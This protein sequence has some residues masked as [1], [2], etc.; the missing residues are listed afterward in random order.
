[1]QQ[2]KDNVIL[3]INHD[4]ILN[5][6]GKKQDIVITLQEKKGRKEDEGDTKKKEG[7]YLEEIR[8]AVET[9]ENVDDKINYAQKYLDNITNNL[10]I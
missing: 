8:L 10:K 2:K 5:A 9:P 3:E 7:E 4:H 6:T 1:M